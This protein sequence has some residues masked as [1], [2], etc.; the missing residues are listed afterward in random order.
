MKPIIKTV[1]YLDE[2]ILLNISY[3]QISKK[4]KKAQIVDLL[5][6]NNFLDTKEYDVYLYQQMYTNLFKNILNKV[7][8]SNKIKIYSE[9]N[10]C[11]YLQNNYFESSENI[12]VL[13]NSYYEAASNRY[14]S[15]KKDFY[16]FYKKIYN[17]NKI[18]L[19]FRNMHV[20]ISDLSSYN[21][22]LDE[23]LSI[24]EIKNNKM[25]NLVYFY[26]NT[27]S[28]KTRETMLHNTNETVYNVQ[29][30]IEGNI[31]TYRPSAVKLT[32]WSNRTTTGND[33]FS[34][35]SVP[36]NEDMVDNSG[37]RYASVYEMIK[38]YLSTITIETNDVPQKYILEQEKQEFIDNTDKPLVPKKFRGVDQYNSTLSYRLYPTLSEGYIKPFE[39]YFAIKYFIK[40]SL[41]NENKLL[42]ILDNTLK[43]KYYHIKTNTI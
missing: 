32:F 8:I 4:N 7:N 18:A 41:F 34:F 12:H 19:D 21:I 40:N 3:N 11:K 22:L 37:L 42:D 31:R 24:N 26:E 9:F 15:P 5:Y 30:N 35:S 16:T 28:D 10:L 33:N 1:L 14:Y 6:E 17:N 39:R 27:Y 2:T 38:F 25:S 36:S 20:I 23:L 29:K 13:W 43:Q